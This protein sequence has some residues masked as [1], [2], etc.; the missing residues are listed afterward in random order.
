[1]LKEYQDLLDEAN[2]LK[3]EN[4][5][6]LDSFKKMKDKQVDEAIH[7]AHDKAFSCIDCLK[8]A[9]CCKTTGPLFT[10]KDV[11]RIAKH[12][13]MKPGDFITKYL[14][15]D[16]DGDYVLQ[17]TPCVFLGSDN[18]CRIYEVRPKACAEYPHTDMRDQ[19]KILSLT[20]KNA[21]ICPAVA[22]VLKNV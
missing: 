13:K 19:R 4:R 22:F 2:S 5:K 8:C 16:E 11:E 6:K 10:Q 15:L 17:S 14:R 3:K 12:Q 9:N 20:L 18:Y 21:E 1:M 7:D